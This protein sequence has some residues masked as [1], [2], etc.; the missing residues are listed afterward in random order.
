MKC[1]VEKICGGCSLLKLKPSMQADKKK[2]DVEE[3]VEKAHLKVRV[4]DV[5]SGKE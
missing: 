5:H 2:K 4:G 1:K 3:L